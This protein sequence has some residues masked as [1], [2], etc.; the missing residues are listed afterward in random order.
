MKIKRKAMAIWVILLLVVM[1][2]NIVEANDKTDKNQYSETS[3]I[4]IAFIEEDGSFETETINMTEEEISQLEKYVANFF[5]KINS[6]EDWNLQSL[7]ELFKYFLKNNIFSR[8]FKRIFSSIFNF[9]KKPYVASIGHGLRL[10]PFKK[11]SMKLTKRFSFW[12]YSSGTTFVFSPWK[13][14]TRFYHGRQIGVIR[15]FRGIYLYFAKSFSEKSTTF[16]MGRAKIVKGIQ[17]PF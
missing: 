10:N 6:N 2:F 9:F 12:R 14:D 4:E 16:F 17:F 3:T 11:S 7:F 5:E 1:T 15:E 8:F 13:L